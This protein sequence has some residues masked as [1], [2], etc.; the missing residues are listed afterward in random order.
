MCDSPLSSN[1]ERTYFFNNCI[2]EIL[3]KCPNCGKEH[4]IEIIRAVGLKIRITSYNKNGK[5]IIS[6][7]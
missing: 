2:M 7:F 4:K 3:V 5:P 6:I 1:T